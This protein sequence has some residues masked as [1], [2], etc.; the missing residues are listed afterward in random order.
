[1]GKKK[2]LLVVVSVPDA[3]QMDDETF[4]NHIEKRHA[5]ECKVEGYIK[6]HAVSAWIGVWR[7]YH[8]RLHMIATPGQH[9]HVHEWD[10]ELD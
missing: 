6:R 8:E 10:E 3:E 2:D 7:A 9:D 4:L 1:M 5:K